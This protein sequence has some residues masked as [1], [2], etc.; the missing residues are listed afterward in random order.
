MPVSLP[1][2]LD[3]S[4]LKWIKVIHDPS[5]WAY[6]R[7]RIKEMSEG[8]DC[9]DVTVFPL[10]FTNNKA[11]TVAFSDQLALI[12]RGKL[13]HVVEVMDRQPYQGGGWYHRMCRILW[14]KP[15]I[16]DWKN[17]PPQKELLGFDPSLGDGKPHALENLSHFRE[18]WNENGSTA[19]FKAFLE[20]RL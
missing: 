14:W 8:V 4:N 18:R 12:Q 10:G 19:G 5:G 7:K 17:L 13:T 16:D 6:T 20:A 9:N 15:E 3:L 2:R 1:N 11:S